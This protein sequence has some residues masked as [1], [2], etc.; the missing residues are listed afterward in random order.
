MSALE[1]RAQESSVAV[2]IETLPPAGQSHSARRG[3]VAR[4]GRVGIAAAWIALAGLL[5]S[6]WVGQASAATDDDEP[7]AKTSAGKAKGAGKKKPA[8]DEPASDDVPDGYRRERVKEIVLWN[9]HNGKRHDN[10]ARP[11]I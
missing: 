5:L 3:L 4:L 8:D 10:G 11:A 1:S 9:E 6:A 7:A 2:G